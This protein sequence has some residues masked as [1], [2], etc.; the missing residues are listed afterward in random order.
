[1]YK[2]QFIGDRKVCGVFEFVRCSATLLRIGNV[3]Q[4]VKYE[5]LYLN[6]H[7]YRRFHPL[8]AQRFILGRVLF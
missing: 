2:I 6:K 5:F 7:D 3:Q 4:K 1:L 8:M